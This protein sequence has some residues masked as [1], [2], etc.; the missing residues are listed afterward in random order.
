[1]ASSK[2]KAQA[3]ITSSENTETSELSDQDRYQMIAEAA[4]YNAEL[5]EFKNGDPEQD[6][7]LA[8]EQID[9]QLHV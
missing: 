4:Y 9:Q 1:M 7:Y 2:N 3:N 6:W 5:R 8:E